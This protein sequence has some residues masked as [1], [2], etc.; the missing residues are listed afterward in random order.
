[1][2]SSDTFEDFGPLNQNTLEANIDERTRGEIT[3]DADLSYILNTPKL[4]LSN[5]LIRLEPFKYLWDISKLLT[6]D[7]CQLL[8][9]RTEEIGYGRTQ[10][11]PKYRG[12]LRLILN[13]C[14]LASSLWPRIQVLLGPDFSLLD[15][16]KGKWIPIGLNSRFRFAKY[17]PGDAFGRHA[18]DCYIEKEN[19]LMSMLTVNI[20]LNDC[21]SGATRFYYYADD[22]EDKK[23]KE[24]KEHK[25]QIIDVLPTTGRCVIFRQ[26]PGAEYIHAG[27]KV[28][29]DFKFLMRTDVMF[30]QP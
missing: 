13:D 22:K 12:N 10:Y 25:D 27:L 4:T 2:Q 5:S 1:M 6:E 18:D 9:D 3:T 28:E 29:S 7:E 24:E 21:T 11:N 14:N 26:L 16:H 20:Y 19:S 23:E 17:Y 8:I 30:V 15:K